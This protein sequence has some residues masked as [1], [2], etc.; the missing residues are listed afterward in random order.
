MEP[1]TIQQEGPSLYPENLAGNAE[2]VRQLGTW[3]QYKRD[4]FSA[5]RKPYSDSWDNAD[6]MYKCG[7]DLAKL[8]ANQSAATRADTASTLYFT[9]VNIIHA[10][11]IRSMLSRETPVRYSPR[12]SSNMFTSAQEGEQLAGQVTSLL[13]WQAEQDKFLLKSIEALLQLVKYGNLPVCCYWKEKRALRTIRSPIR[14]VGL[15]GEMNVAGYAFDTVEKLVESWPTLDPILNEN[16]YADPTIGNIQDQNCIVIAALMN[17]DEIRGMGEAGHWV[18]TDKVTEAHLYNGADIDDNR[19]DN[20][21]G[22]AGISDTD[23]T[24]TGQY[25]VWHVWG[26]MPVNGGAWDKKATPKI[27]HAVFVGNDMAGGIC[28]KVCRNYDP[29]DQYP[30]EMLHLLP[31]EQDALYHLGLHQVLKSNWDEITTAKNQSIDAKTLQ[32]KRPLKMI[33]GEVFT[34][35][36]SYEQ[37]KVIVVERQESLKEMEVANNV[38]EPMNVV[39]MLE[40]DSKRAASTDRP[41]MGEALGGRTSATEASNVFDQSMVVP[42]I[43]T[44]YVLQ[45]YL[46]F[47]AS[48]SWRL[49]EL[50]APDELVVEITGET[51]ASQISPATLYGEYDIQLDILEDIET[52]AVMQQ[53]VPFMLQAIVPNFGEFIDKRELLKRI[54]EWYGVKNPSGLITDA[55][56]F[57]AERVARLENAMMI[58]GLQMVDPQQG[59]DFDVHIR[60]HQTALVDYNGLEYRF[61]GV[62][63][64]RQHIEKTKMMKDMARMGGSVPMAMPPG[65]TTPGMVAGNQIAAAQ[66]IKA[67]MPA[68]APAQ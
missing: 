39:A 48:K 24:D 36:L 62:A 54:F 38:G 25:R 7:Q 22:N 3:A 65:N 40:S 8:H 37:N 61:P 33:R 23:K 19:R 5:K 14:S 46:G 29:D 27:H 59:E 45:Q 20:K 49:W 43:R 66:G 9:Q 2:L 35:N 52:N 17:L 68:L 55:N 53:Q 60:E 4:R 51:Q 11:L 15:N 30:I 18:N 12:Y 21:Q 6:F 32:V 44:R 13:K 34:K 67:N 26:R 64:L 31:D 41:V 10:M 56:V 42:A 16:F 50:Y 47:W 28:M 63:L 1:G 57:D 58:E